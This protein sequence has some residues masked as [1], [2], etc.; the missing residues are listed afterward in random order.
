MNLYL[1][2]SL[3]DEAFL[4]AAFESVVGREPDVIGLAHYVERLRSGASRALVLA[5][6]RSS[7]EGQAHAAH[8]PDRELDILQRRYRRVRGWP[9]GRWRWIFL[10]RYAARSPRRDFDWA[11]WF[12]H[13]SEARTPDHASAT[14]GPET[15]NK[16]AAIERRV[17]ALSAALQLQQAVPLLGESGAAE[18]KT[19]FIQQTVSEAYPPAVPL[20]EV[21]W[22]ARSI[23]AQM[24]QHISA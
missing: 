7:V 12:S 8:A 24:L 11:L 1:L 14:T 9:L 13:Y 20:T 23:Y 17:D 10:P 22:A 4:P 5:E 2:L 15:E 21:S 18:Q 19:A 6:M 16:L 3:P